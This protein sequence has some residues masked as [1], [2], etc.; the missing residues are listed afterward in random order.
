[1]KNTS[2][3]R[4]FLTKVKNAEFDEFGQLV[5][6]PTLRKSEKLTGLN[7]TWFYLISFRLNNYKN[8]FSLPLLHPE[9]EPRVN[10]VS[11]SITEVH[12]FNGVTFFI[13]YPPPPHKSLVDVF[14]VVFVPRSAQLGRFGPASIAS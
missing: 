11:I 4:R 8:I 10:L 3:S 7:K 9:P 14:N 1:M 2:E 5:K 6:T 13:S 12:N